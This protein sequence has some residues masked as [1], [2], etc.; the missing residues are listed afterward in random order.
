MANFDDLNTIASNSG[1]QGRCMYA[2]YVSAV[3]VM[4]EVSSTTDHNARADYARKVLRGNENAFNI[5][6]TV[7]TNPSIAANAD[8]G[9]TPDYSIPDGDIQF[10]ANS[11]FNALAGLANKS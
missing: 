9:A 11:I 3:N 10:T 8:A 1:F 6:L 2:I 4:A 7:L 5:A